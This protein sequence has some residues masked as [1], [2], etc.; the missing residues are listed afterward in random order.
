MTFMKLWSTIWCLLCFFLWR[1]HREVSRVS[2]SSRCA[3]SNGYNYSHLL[4]YSSHSNKKWNAPNAWHTLGRPTCS[5]PYNRGLF[6]NSPWTMALLKNVRPVRNIVAEAAANSQ[7]RHHFVRQQPLFIS[8]PRR[9]WQLQ[10]EHEK[11]LASPFCA[12]KGSRRRA[13]P[14]F[15]AGDGWWRWGWIRSM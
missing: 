1:S 8:L 5:V 3:F 10:S 15:T 11:G 7:F 2:V 13:L 4:S 12:R 9:Q 14:R 6:S